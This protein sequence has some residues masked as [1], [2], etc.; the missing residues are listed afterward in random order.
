V[1]QLKVCMEAKK[2]SEMTQF[3]KI[4]VNCVQYIVLQ[5][6][7]ETYYKLD[8]NIEVKESQIKFDTVHVSFQVHNI[9]RFCSLLM[10]SNL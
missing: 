5:A 8:L 6:V 7:A 10:Q 1:G 3:T 2:M 9:L 4:I